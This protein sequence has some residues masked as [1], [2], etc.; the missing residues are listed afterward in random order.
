MTLR[1]S[2]VTAVV[3]A[4]LATSFGCK[5]NLAERMQ[6]AGDEREKDAAAKAKGLV[7]EWEKGLASSFPAASAPRASKEDPAMI[8]WRR[9]GKDEEFA[10]RAEAMITEF[11]DT[12]AGELLKEGRLLFDASFR[13]WVGTEL[14]YLKEGAGAAPDP[15]APTAKKDEIP[16][17]R[18]PIM[19][20]AGILRQFLQKHPESPFA[21]VAAFD[22]FFLPIAH[23]YKAPDYFGVGRITSFTPYYQILWDFPRKELEEYEY[24]RDRLM[25]EKV[26]GFGEKL[27][28]EFR[29]L[30]VQKPWLE[31]L[32]VSIGEAK[33]TL[34][35]SPLAATL[36]RFDADVKAAAAKIV[37]PEEYPVL[38]G[39]RSTIA[40][41]PYT[42]LVVGPKGVSFET[43]KPGGDE[44]RESKELLPANAKLDYAPAKLEDGLKK[45]LSDLAMRQ[46]DRQYL[47]DL[48]LHAAGTVPVSI[49]EPISRGLIA[50]EATW[51]D[52]VA[53]RREDGTLRLKRIPL[54]LPEKQAESRAYTTPL[55]KWS[56]T[57]VGN[58]SD[59]NSDAKIPPEK[60][61][62]AVFDDGKQAAPMLLGETT[63]EAPAAVKHD[64]N[65]LGGLL[66][67]VYDREGPV[68]LG[69]HESV[70]QAQMHEV[71][72]AVAYKECTA[73]PEC[74]GK[75]V[76]RPD[77]LLMVCR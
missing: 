75:M 30:A 37:I 77:L 60:A 13:F 72:N 34:A 27:P 14:A 55:G 63:G 28:F 59:P 9:A 56:C 76:L 61:V 15:S 43:D 16:R 6:K 64:A 35:G 70:N 20:Y 57:F 17:R 73:T 32:A 1:A 40:A 23:F 18:T 12:K 41:S 22:L 74:K 54:I 65:A 5:S 19:E 8:G 52:L 49:L 26:P 66:T 39:T 11:G 69:F 2:L 29:D 4:A 21:P 71:F 58:T 48:D 46:T 47:E 53:R 44:E 45:A 42:V 36:D 50:R 24:Y 67:F 10:K 38:A 62:A 51:F 25:K 68:V 3:G 7:E 33:K 31:K